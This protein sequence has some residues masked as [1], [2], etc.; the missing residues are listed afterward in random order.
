[1]GQMH[2][3]LSQEVTKMATDEWLF[4]W[5]DIGKYLGKSAKTAQRYA[6]NGMPFFS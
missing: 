1:M 3:N 6:K 5:K 2:Q 4:G